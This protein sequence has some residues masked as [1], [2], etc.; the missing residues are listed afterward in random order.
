MFKNIPLTSVKRIIPGLFS[1]LKVKFTDI[2]L[3]QN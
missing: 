1:I 3:S 2:G